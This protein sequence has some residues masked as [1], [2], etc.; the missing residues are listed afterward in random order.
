MDRFDWVD[1]RQA[2]PWIR[3]E[4]DACG[5][6]SGPRSFVNAIFPRYDPGPRKE[7]A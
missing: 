7:A 3:Q 6:Y 2:Q 4:V 1:L 5:S